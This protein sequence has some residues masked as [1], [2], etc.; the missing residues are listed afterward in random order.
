MSATTPA[1]P[2]PYISANCLV[3]RP[4]V[5]S[6]STLPMSPMCWLI[7]ASRPDARQK[8]FFSSPPTGML[9]A[10]SKGGGPGGGG[11]CAAAAPNGQD[12]AVDHAQHRVVAG[13]MDGA[14][15]D[16][17]GASDGAEAPP[18]GDVVMAERLDP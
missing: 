9:G 15:V 5:P 8:V 14:V 13:G 7:Q 12:L 1:S 4:N 10:G 3:V 6:V 11:V 18:R 16:Q 17:P 2:T